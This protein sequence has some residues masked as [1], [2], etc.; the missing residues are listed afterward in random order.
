MRF[1]KKLRLPP[2]FALPRA[3]VVRQQVRV[4]EAV[5][6][7]VAGTPTEDDIAVCATE[8]AVVAELARLAF[9]QPKTHLV[10]V[11]QIDALRVPLLDAVVALAEAREQFKATGTTACPPEYNAALLTFADIADQLRDALPRRL[12]LLALRAVARELK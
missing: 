8:T 3:E 12:W 4:H 7:I 1:T 11:E 10:P 2:A 5:R 9:E 6:A